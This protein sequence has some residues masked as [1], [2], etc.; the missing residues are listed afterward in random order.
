MSVAFLFLEKGLYCHLLRKIPK[1][2]GFGE[3]HFFVICREQVIPE[4]AARH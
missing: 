3:T 1:K 4:G 2:I